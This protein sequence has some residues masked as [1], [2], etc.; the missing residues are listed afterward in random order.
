MRLII[1]AAAL[2]LTCP[3][4]PAAAGGCPHDNGRGHHQDFAEMARCFA[5]GNDGRHEAI[6]RHQRVQQQRGID[7]SRAAGN[8]GPQN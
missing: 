7:Q 1:A 5:Y 3:V 6:A 8:V 2:L 4:L